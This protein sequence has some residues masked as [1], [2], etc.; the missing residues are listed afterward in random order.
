MSLEN[1]HYGPIIH[2][3]MLSYIVDNTLHLHRL[4]LIIKGK[5]MLSSG[6]SNSRSLLVPDWYSNRY[7]R[8][9]EL[10][11]KGKTQGVLSLYN[12]IHKV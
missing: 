5:Y 7:C 10:V 12:E 9:L 8:V 11:H 4:I 2:F 6:C 1:K 3:V